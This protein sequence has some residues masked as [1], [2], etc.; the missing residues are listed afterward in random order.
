MSQPTSQGGATLDQLPVS[1]DFHESPN[2]NSSTSRE[3]VTLIV[4]PE[5]TSASSTQGISPGEENE[6]EPEKVELPGIAR[7]TERGRR[8]VTVYSWARTKKCLNMLFGTGVSV[9]V[10]AGIGMIYSIYHTLPW[11]CWAL[12][13]SGV[14]ISVY[15]RHFRKSW[16]MSKD[17]LASLEG[18]SRF[19]RAEVIERAISGTN[20]TQEGGEDPVVLTREPEAMGTSFDSREGQEMDSL[21]REAPVLSRRTTWANH[22]LEDLDEVG[23]RRRRMDTE[24]AIGL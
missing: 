13:C 6:I 14:R 7:F 8:L 16:V 2:N 12:L 22:I 19:R 18:V 24:E 9:S 17:L 11:L 1:P 4:T 20:G 21:V 15:L 23:H 3:D 5:G 10:W